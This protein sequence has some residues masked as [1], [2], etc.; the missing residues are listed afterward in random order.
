MEANSLLTIKDN[1]I[2]EIA[3]TGTLKIHSDNILLN[4]LESKVLVYGTLEILD[5]E[6]F[7]VFGNGRFVFAPG[8][9]LVLGNGAKFAVT[10]T[11]ENDIKVELMNSTI[12][13][14]DNYDIDI[15]TCKILLNP[16]SK[17]T[18]TDI[19]VNMDEVNISGVNKTS[20][21]EFSQLQS[22]NVFDS[23][24]EKMYYAFKLSNTTIE[25]FFYNCEFNNNSKSIYLNSVDKLKVYNTYFYG[26]S[27]STNSGIEL[28]N[29]SELKLLNCDFKYLASGLQ[30]QNIN[31]ISSV[32]EIENCDFENC[33]SGARVHNVETTGFD[34]CLFDNNSVGIDGIFSSLI[35]FAN[36]TIEN[37]ETGIRVQEVTKLS[38]NT[39]NNNIH[40][41]NNN[42]LESN[43]DA[44]F[45]I[46][47]TIFISKKTIIDNND[48]GIH[49][50]GEDI[51]QNML[52]VGDLGCVSII[53]NET[54][55]SGN[56]FFLDIDAQIHAC[57]RG[58][59]NSIMPI[60]F[61]G[62]GTMLDVCY[63]TNT[64]NTILA[65]E[66]YWGVDNQNNP[67]GISSFNYYL[68]DNCGSNTNTISI[69]DSDWRNSSACGLTFVVRVPTILIYVSKLPTYSQYKNGDYNE[70]TDY[71][72]SEKLISEID[73]E[74][75]ELIMSSD[76]KIPSEDYRTVADV[77]EEG[78][79][80]YL[81]EN[82]SEAI[83]KLNVIAN[84]SEELFDSN[85]SKYLITKAI[86]LVGQCSILPN[87]I[88]Q[89]PSGKK[90]DNDELYVD[91]NEQFK[92]ELS[93]NP[94][95][96]NIFIKSNEEGKL[97]YDI[98]NIEGKLL[99]NGYFNKTDYIDLSILNKGLYLINVYMDEQLIY[100]DKIVKL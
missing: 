73:D 23:Y 99:L 97:K 41:F 89:E 90:S 33:G 19:N 9:Q 10:G 27:S 39:Q 32:I 85:E 50:E 76:E 48:R 60:N 91:S 28:L 22:L 38:L 84:L 21:L 75:L 57:N 64:P 65:R 2:L 40:Y 100:T 96:N 54:G 34:H 67:S 6:D 62:N 71:D 82:Y 79:R 25:P 95:E 12:L 78:Y 31:G 37:C 55:I 16:N 13:N 94:F 17:I 87:N 53:N 36:G 43:G 93:P 1:A 20:S 77:F 72:Y 59:C 63:N 45:G 3:P 26:F 14:L 7:D 24:F 51:N 44:I 58:N 29:F 88:Y 70:E 5:D 15:S 42:I 18:A 61:S 52:V 69:D 11:S 66:N 68:N 4:N 80:T 8:S 86:N 30:A 81:S 92:I 47:S 56:D 35:N 83:D 74:T 49:L 46:N 98:Y